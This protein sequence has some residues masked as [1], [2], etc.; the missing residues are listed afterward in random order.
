MRYPKTT[1][2]GSVGEVAFSFSESQLN[3]QAAGEK[4]FNATGYGANRFG[5]LSKSN[6]RDAAKY[7][8]Q[9]LGTSAQF[10]DA[11]SRNLQELGE[12]P[13]NRNRGSINTLENNFVAGQ[14]SG[15]LRSNNKAATQTM[16]SN[17][18][19]GAQH[20]SGTA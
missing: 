4:R 2:A 8:T 20:E 1:K 7:G 9:R 6:Q 10:V 16:G 12:T 13:Q 5:I 15:T 17:K 18:P 19:E 14:S 11:S 3:E